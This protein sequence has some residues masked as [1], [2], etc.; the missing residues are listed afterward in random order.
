V[1]VPFYLTT[2]GALLA[3][4]G[5]APGARARYEESLELA[6]RTSM[7]FY[8][9]ET[10][11]RLAHLEAEPQAVAANLR[12]ALDLARSQAARPFEL[13]I[14]LDLHTLLGEPAR[15]DLQQAVDVFGE[16]ATTTELDEARARLMTAR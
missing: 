15:A 13:R 11:R 14:A 3:G 6:S 16:G 5:D 12:G 8:D 10:R 4:A 7:C 2:T 9:A 1:F